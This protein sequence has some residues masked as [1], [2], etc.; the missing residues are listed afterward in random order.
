MKKLEGK[1]KGKTKE[2]QKKGTSLGG[3]IFR[4]DG[5]ELAATL[6]HPVLIHPIPYHLVLIRPCGDTLYISPI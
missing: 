3:A 5:A 2:K 1:V 4:W 6:I